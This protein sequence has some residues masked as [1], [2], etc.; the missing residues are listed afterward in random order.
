MLKHASTD[1]GRISAGE[2]FSDLKQLYQRHGKKIKLAQSSML[3]RGAACH[4]GAKAPPS[5]VER[6]AKRGSEPTGSATQQS[7]HQ[8]AKLHPF[9]IFKQL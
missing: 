1:A 6:P 8:Q 3:H 5:R 9:T 7:H 2:T 4:T